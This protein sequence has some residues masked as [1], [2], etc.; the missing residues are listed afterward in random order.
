MKQRE[1]ADRQAAYSQSTPAKALKLY[2]KPAFRYEKVF[3]TNALTCGKIARQGPCH[4]NR[5]TS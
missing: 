1:E 5:K 2:Q 4:S 3:E